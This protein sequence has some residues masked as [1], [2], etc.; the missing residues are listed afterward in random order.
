MERSMNTSA[1]DYMSPENLLELERIRRKA[2]RYIQSNP[3]PGPAIFNKVEPLELEAMEQL[4][5][6]RYPRFTAC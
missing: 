1:P 5:S 3:P 6:H 4:D 2:Q